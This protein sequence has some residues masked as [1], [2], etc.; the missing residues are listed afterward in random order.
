M[1]QKHMTN[2]KRAL[3]LFVV[4][5]FVA[6]TISKRGITTQD[7]V[8]KEVQP[9]VITEK[10]PNDTDDPAIWINPTEPSK[11]L[12]LGTDKGDTT[13]GIYVFD[14]A[15]KIDHKKSVLHLKRPN[16]I[17]IEYGFNY[18]GIS[19][20]IA[21]F[22][23]RGRNM[24]RVFSLPDMKEIDG[25]GIEV[26][27]GESQRDPMGI[28]LFKDHSGVYAIVGRKSGPNG[29]FIWQYRLETNEKGVVKG[30]KVRAFGNF[31]GKKEIESIVVDDALGYVYYSDE[32]VGVRQF[33]ASADSSGKELA[34]FATKGVKNDHEG[35]SVFPTSQTTGYILLS[36]QQANRFQIFSRE[37]SAGQP[38]EHKLV[39]VVKV[40]A[41]DSDGSDVTASALNDTFKHGLF[42]AMS[43]DKTF[44]YYRWEDIAGK[45]LIADPKVVV[46]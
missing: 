4:L 17:D 43:T 37:G 33:Y 46:K 13:G 34:L 14:L 22:T 28:S 18:N 24:I 3:H 11:S 40:A 42:V 16:N 31:S 15:G 7:V 5:Y 39:K 8:N 25:G 10:T 6:C 1:P 9:A 27:Q 38:F 12:V 32:T 29:S 21:V 44:H 2:L 20:D 45:T 36:D 41:R 35:L 26:F 19:T 30:K 23:E